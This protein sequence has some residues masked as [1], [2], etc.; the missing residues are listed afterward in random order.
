MGA[1]LRE[2]HEWKFPDGQ[3]VGGII[4][5]GTFLSDDQLLDVVRGKMESIPREKGVI[6]D[7][8]PRRIGQAKFLLEYLRQ[9]ERKGFVTIFLD[10]PEAESVRRL[11]RRAE[12]E[13]RADDTPDGIKH[14][15]QQYQEVT[16]PMLDYLREQ[17]VFLDVDGSP[18]IPEVERNV[19]D[20]LQID[21]QK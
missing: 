12:I 14:R 1:I 11:L 7:G 19:A 15:L 10:V 2:N 21:Q 16:V 4:D 13:G 6:F 3:T 9:Q 5:G 18:S 17:T 8:I 20:A